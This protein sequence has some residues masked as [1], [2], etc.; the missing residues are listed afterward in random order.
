MVYRWQHLT[1]PLTGAAS[2]TIGPG[3]MLDSTVPLA[4]HDGY[5]RLGSLDYPYTVIGQDLYN[6]IMWKGHASYAPVHVWY[7]RTL[8]LGAVYPWPVTSAGV[9]HVFHDAPLAHLALN[10]VLL[11]HVGYLDALI[12]AL[13]RR[14]ASTYG[15]QLDP[16][17]LEEARKAEASLRRRMHRPVVATI[18]MPAGHYGIDP[19]YIYTGGF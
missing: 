16:L 14:E 12:Y 2:Y 6:Q 5:T 15:Q 17:Y 3:G 8:P 19:D 4:V 18:H 7:E 11:L 13:G 9:L 1:T 10:D